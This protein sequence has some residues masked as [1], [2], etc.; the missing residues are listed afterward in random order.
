M[1]I[2]DGPANGTTA[3]FDCVLPDG[4]V[5]KVKYGMTGEI[6]AEMP[7]AVC[8]PGSALA[9]TGSLVV[10]PHCY[11]CV[12]TPSYTVKVLDFVH[13]RET[14]ARNVPDDS[15]T[16]FEWVAVERRLGGAEIDAGDLDGWSWHELD[17]VDPARGASRA[18]RDALRL[19]AVLIAHWDNK[20]ANQRLVCLSSPASDAPCDPPFAYIHDLGATFGPNKVEL[21]S[22]RRPRSGPTRAAARSACGSFPTMAARFPTPR[23]LKLGRR[24]IADQMARLTRDQL[25][26]LFT[27][28]R[29]P[30]FH[31]WRGSPA[32][33]E[34]WAAA[35]LEKARRIIDAGPC[36]A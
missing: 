20:P 19:L 30:E 9:P 13:A 24:L 14:L 29:F 27:A 17:A 23:S 25:L 8:S 31:G 12:R 21:R 5:I 22:G 4:E 35:F 33:A 7:R 3:K 15:Y 36:P 26:G 1:P 28:A 16:D 10:A 11:Q 18:E 2:L 34:H 6:Q 32:A